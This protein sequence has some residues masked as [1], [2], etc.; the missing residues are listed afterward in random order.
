MPVQ[1]HLTAFQSWK[2]A[3]VDIYLSP[4]QQTLGLDK[5]RAISWLNEWTKI[6]NEENKASHKPPTDCQLDA[7]R[8]LGNGSE[9]TTCGVCNSTDYLGIVPESC[10]LFE[11]AS[12]DN[13]WDPTDCKLEFLAEICLVLDQATLTISDSLLSSQQWKGKL[14]RTA[15]GVPFQVLLQSP[16]RH[17][18]RLVPLLSRVLPPWEV[19]PLL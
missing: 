2:V 9:A 1:Y 18:C 4:I 13:L 5:D 3:A 6:R 12:L 14:T 11:N 15:Q 16:H 8:Y 7:L 10:R 17:R 19:V